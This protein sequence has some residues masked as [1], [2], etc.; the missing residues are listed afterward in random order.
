MLEHALL[1]VRPG[2]ESDFEAAM[3]EALP[4]IEGADECH[5]AEVRRQVE[6]AS[7]YLLLVRWTS[8]EAHMAF[9][10]T[11]RY[12]AWRALTH[13]FYV[14]TLSVTHFFEPIER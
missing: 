11:A 8:V 13:H 4:I 7:T 12:E 14:G 10:A 3:R 1:T 6:D 5:G 2:S 9:R